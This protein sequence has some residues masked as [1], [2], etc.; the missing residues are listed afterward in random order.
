MKAK[1]NLKIYKTRADAESVLD[2]AGLKKIGNNLYVPHQPWRLQ[3]GEYALPQYSISKVRGGY[4]I[5]WRI[6]FY[7]G[8]LNAPK[9]GLVNVMCDGVQ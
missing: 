4:R 1:A 5:L 2:A 3:H 9:G 6:D 8:A 7:R